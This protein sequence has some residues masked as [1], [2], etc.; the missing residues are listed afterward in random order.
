MTFRVGFSPK[1]WGRSVP[2]AAMKVSTKVTSVK[3]AR[4]PKTN[5]TKT[6]TR[7]HIIADL[8]FYHIA[9]ILTKHHFAVTE[10]T[11]DYGYD[12]LAHSFSPS[13]E[14]EAGHIYVQLKATEAVKIGKRNKLVSFSAEIRDLILWSEQ[15]TPVY[16]VIFC[17]KNKNCYWVD[18]QI[19]LRSHGVDPRDLRAKGRHYLTIHLPSVPIDGSHIDSWRARKNSMMQ[20]LREI[21]K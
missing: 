14:P 21:A 7:G 15:P 4:Y 16:L 19:Y 17:A 11:R 13:G 1:Q 5:V 3:F 18:V 12:L 8:S 20:R 6:R 2:L 10:I 9:Y